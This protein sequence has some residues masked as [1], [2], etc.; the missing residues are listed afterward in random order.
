MNPSINN[1]NCGNFDNQ[2]IDRL[3]DGE[4]PE[5]DRRELLQSFENQPGGWRR[6]ALAFLEAQVWRQALS[7]EAAP[8][9]ASVASRPIGTRQGRKSKFWRPMARMTA[10]AASL[11][12]AFALGWTYHR[13][14]DETHHVIAGTPQESATTGTT[15][16]ADGPASLPQR[17]VTDDSKT[18]L[19]KVLG[20][21]QAMHGSLDSIMKRWQQEGYSVETQPCVVS[22]QAKDGRK[23]NL[24]VQE[25]RVRYVGDRVY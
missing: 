18:Q 13:G 1:R 24:P 25:V 4:L 15:L 8:E 23:I 2:L 11:A 17:V 19:T 14:H 3:V 9:A 20:S 22:V 21:M 16:V 6:C 10:L 7:P 5:T 12:A